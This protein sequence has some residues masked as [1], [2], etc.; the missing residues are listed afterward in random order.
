M[1]ANGQYILKRGGD[2]IMLM[3]LRRSLR[4]GDNINVTLTF[5]KAGRMTIEVPVDNSQ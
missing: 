4:Q 1:P 2:H 5:K 3:G